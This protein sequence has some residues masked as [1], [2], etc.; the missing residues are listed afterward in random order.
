MVPVLLLPRGQMESGSKL[1]CDVFLSTESVNSGMFGGKICQ[2]TTLNKETS[3]GIFL[4]S[5]R[6]P[7][8]HP[9][10]ARSRV[11]ASTQPAGEPRE[12]APPRA[13]PRRLRPSKA[14]DQR[15]Q[16]EMIC[17]VEAAAGFDSVGDTQSDT[18]TASL[19]IFKFM[20]QRTSFVSGTKELT[21]H[22]NVEENST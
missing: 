22:Q 21:K 5:C 19:F 11:T 3:S 18:V 13:A 8:V 16:C 20:R 4:L 10:A 6:F 7:V 1:F 12:E 17:I 2:L 14:K 15:Q 9:V